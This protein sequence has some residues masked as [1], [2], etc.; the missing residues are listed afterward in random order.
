MVQD[1]RCE[2]PSPRT[3]S[4]C[5]PWLLVLV[6]AL[7]F[8]NVPQNGFVWEDMELVVENQFIRSFTS[9]RSFLTPAYWRQGHVAPRRAYKPATMWSFAVEYKLWRLNPTAY[10]VSN[11]ALHGANTVLLL[12]LLRRLLDSRAAFIAALLFAVH[13]IHT[14]AVDWVKNRAD[15]LS[16]FF[17]LT[18]LNL[19]VGRW[20][21]GG[22]P[23]GAGLLEYSV[24][25]IRR[26]RS[27]ASQQA[28]PPRADFTPD[29]KSAALGDRPAVRPGWRTAAALLA[30][31][32]AVTSKGMGL[33]LCPLLVLYVLLFRHPSRWRSALVATWP[34]WLVAAIYLG[35]LSV[36][37]KVD[38]PW[39][40]AATLAELDAASAV[41][42]GLTYIG[43]LAFPSGLNMDRGLTG[44]GI[45]GLGVPLALILLLMA[46]H[47]L[48]M[49]AWRGA[50]AF[51]LCWV[52]LTLIPS[53][54]LAQVA[55]RLLAEQRLYLPSAGICM[56][57]GMGTAALGRSPWGRALAMGLALQ[58][59]AATMHRGFDWR[60]DAAIW[61]D[62]LRKCPGS[63]RAH[64]M[65]AQAYTV[66]GH[67]DRAIRACRTS[68]SL[69]PVY[70][71]AYLILGTALDQKGD[72]RAAMAALE[73]TVEGFPDH[74]HAHNILGTIYYRLGQTEKAV[75]A[76]K[77]AAALNPFIYQPH[78]NLGDAYRMAGH[79]EAA[80]A[81]YRR[82][83]Q[84]APSLVRERSLMA[85]LLLKQGDFRQAA[86]EYESVIAVAPDHPEL[87]NDIGLV[88]QNLGERPRAM[89]AFRKAISLKPKY[90]QAHV[91]LANVLRE[92]D[93]VDEAICAYQD[94]IKADPEFAQAYFNLG[95]ACAAL[96]RREEA[97][98]AYERFLVLWRGA[99]EFA[100]EARA[101]IQRLRPQRP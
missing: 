66:R 54:H 37:I 9:A 51:S 34:F 11:V 71:M 7:A 76:F 17:I 23:N 55:S 47:L 61:S 3:L 45:M 96:G 95:D 83:L 98:A 74:A 13:P 68:L 38:P 99:P 89:A 36:F 35:F 33:A 5:A 27:S 85:N 86:A 30:F 60:S 72:S 58:F 6:T 59:A 91:N 43:L 70:T 50:T 44:G 63:A 64:A 52:A 39:A 84:I 81:E 65:W 62:A 75:A 21:P 41:R 4:R 80:I 90:P 101:S 40:K 77:T 12:A 48:R 16:S 10:H 32:L 88:Y 15:L 92:E 31:V 87:H 2:S 73:R 19:F 42:T 22:R 20:P 93:R 69:P 26:T 18:A 79:L 24:S 49:P 53:L 56:L 28:D 78:A 97:I 14:E 25:A 46:S 94:A 82:A 57:L 100:S 8:L 67:L 1:S 29:P